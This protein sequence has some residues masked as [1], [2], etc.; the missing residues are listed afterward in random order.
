MAKAILLKE[1][2]FSTDW[3]VQSEKRL[4]DEVAKVT[5]TSRSLQCTGTTRENVA[6]TAFII[7]SIYLGIGIV[8]VDGCVAASSSP[9]E[10]VNY[11]CT[12]DFG[13]VVSRKY[14]RTLV[15]PRHFCS[16]Q[17]ATQMDIAIDILSCR[18][19]LIIDKS[20]AK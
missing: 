12:C 20:Q 10:H 14:M 7:G 8:M 13:Y 15:A 5:A 6:S 11:S 4:T 19:I 3:D 1:G 2:V 9:G 18:V 17:Q 16:R